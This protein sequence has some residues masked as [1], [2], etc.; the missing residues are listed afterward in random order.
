MLFAQAW[1]GLKC[2]A[3]LSCTV[4]HSALRVQRKKSIDFNQAFTDKNP[5]RNVTSLP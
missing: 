1:G 4:S 2:L 3:E 5:K